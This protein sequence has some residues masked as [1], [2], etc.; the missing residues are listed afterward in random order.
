MTA[1]LIGLVLSLAAAAAAV[2][3][4][5]IRSRVKAAA[6][7][8]AA[9]AATS[10]HYFMQDAYFHALAH[11]LL[12]GGAGFLFMVPEP[13]RLRPAM[14]R[15]L[16][17]AAAS[18]A[19]FIGLL[20]AALAWRPEANPGW[21]RDGFGAV[22]VVGDSMAVSWIVPLIL[23]ALIVVTLLAGTSLLLKERGK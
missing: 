10:I 23:A 13:G 7:F 21:D 9:L 4:C 20:L 19:L 12:F 11:V 18:A 16:V 2:G 22:P 1:N 3:A 14:R 6:L 15:L 8:A 17:S 5:F